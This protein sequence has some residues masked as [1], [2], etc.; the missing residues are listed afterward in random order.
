MSIEK[1]TCES[2]IV[3]T[4]VPENPQTPC[5]LLGG[6]IRDENG[7]VRGHYHAIVF[8]GRR[9]VRLHLP[10]NVKNEQGEESKDNLVLLEIDVRD[11]RRISVKNVEK[12]YAQPGCMAKEDIRDRGLL[13]FVYSWAHGILDDDRNLRLYCEGAE[14]QMRQ[15]LSQKMRVDI[16]LS[17]L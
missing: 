13:P 8:L 16:C 3:E 5:K 17:S 4:N 2:F 12:R 9:T 10:L 15:E 14:D 6:C 11:G 1:W 7:K